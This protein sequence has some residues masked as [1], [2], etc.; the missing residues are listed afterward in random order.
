MSPSEKRQKRAEYMRRW[1]R[2][3]SELSR[4]IDVRAR[5]KKVEAQKIWARQHYEKNRAAYL[6]RARK[7][8]ER[9]RDAGVRAER[10]R[11][12]QH[13][14][15]DLALKYQR[16]WRKKNPGKVS[17]STMR[18]IAAKARAVPPW[19]DHARIAAVYAEA[20]RL[21]KATGIP[22]HVDHIVPIQ[23][24]QVCGL[25]WHENLRPLPASENSRKGNRFDPMKDIG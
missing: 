17:A 8:Y 13:E 19:A 6:E 2:E 16:T 20:A 15:P 18:R 23:G 4:A 22:H 14:R 1:R 10:S 24:K 21:T 3:K 25:H 9:E 12:L 5:A 11:R 7:Q